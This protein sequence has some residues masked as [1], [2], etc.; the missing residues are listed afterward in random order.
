MAT[1]Y[2]PKIIT[3]G[4]V[5]CLDAGD[6]KSYSGSGTTWTDRSGNGNHFT[7]YNT[8]TFNS[9]GYFIFDGANNYAKISSL[10]L[11]SYDAVTV[12][13]LFR[14][15]VSSYNCP[16]NVL[17]EHSNN[18]N[19]TPLG[20]VASFN[21]TS[22][23][24][25]AASFVSLKGNVG[26]NI[27]A[28]SK[29]YFDSNVWLSHIATYDKSITTGKEVD[30]YLNANNALTGNINSSY[31]SNNTNNF[32]DLPFVIGARGADTYNAS[33]EIASVKIYNRTLTAAEVLQNYN[34]TKGRFGL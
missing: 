34:A 32:G 13:I 4:L 10:D 18:F 12:D 14:P 17:Y 5:L 24:Q 2:S 15:T 3:D 19:G 33:M 29:S 21:D 7:L 23:S 27:Q 9:S 6:S 31:N 28:W 1:S 8:P 16:V 22:V 11:S 20:F 30:L 26:Y 25:D